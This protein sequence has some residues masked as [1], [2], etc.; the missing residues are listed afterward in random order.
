MM[1]MGTGLMHTVALWV[2]VAH[3]TELPFVFGSATAAN[4]YTAAAV[5]LSGDMMNYW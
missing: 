2:L 3:G 1:A 4:G 5:S